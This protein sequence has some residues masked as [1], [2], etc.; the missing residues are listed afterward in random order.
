MMVLRT[1]IALGDRE[2][3]EGVN[4]KSMQWKS[5]ESVISND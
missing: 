4:G 3:L 1:D 2:N 5:V